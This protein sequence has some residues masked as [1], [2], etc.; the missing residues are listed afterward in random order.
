MLNLASKYAESRCTCKNDHNGHS[1][2]GCI[3]Y[4]KYSILRVWDK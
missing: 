1:N 4:N 3:I 2:I